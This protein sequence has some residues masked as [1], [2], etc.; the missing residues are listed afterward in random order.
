[1]SRQMGKLRQEGSWGRRGRRCRAVCG[2]CTPSSWVPPEIDPVA[3]RGL[4][5]VLGVPRSP[6]PMGAAPGA[7]GAAVGS[8]GP[9][10]GCGKENLVLR[11]ADRTNFS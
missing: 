8:E 9:C 7:A 4:A 2:L 10:G 3:I 5:G 1:M 6:Q 11:R